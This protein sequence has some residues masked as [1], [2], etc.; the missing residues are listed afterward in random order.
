[1]V[2]CLEQGADLHMAQLMP[3]PL[4]VSCF[5]K[6]QI[7]FTFL[8][9]AHPG[10]P[11]QRAVKWLCVCVCCVCV[12]G[13]TP[14]GGSAPCTPLGHSPRPPS[15]NDLL[16][17]PLRT[18]SNPVKGVDAQRRAAFLIEFAGLLRWSLDRSTKYRD[19][20]SLSLFHAVSSSPIR[21]SCR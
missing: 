14:I 16:H 17:P 1:V 2:V 5:N 3:L 18:R 12:S 7:G 13:R 8:V 9:P 4:T 15:Q 10:S 21:L 20:L 19:F 6:I 11:E